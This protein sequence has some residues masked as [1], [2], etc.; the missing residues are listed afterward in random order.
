MQ[1]FIFLIYMLQIYAVTENNFSILFKTFLTTMKMIVSII[2]ILFWEILIVFSIKTNRRTD[3]IGKIE[4]QNLITRYDLYDAWRKLNPIKKRYS[5][6]RGNSKSRIDFILCSNGLCSKV[7]D[8]NIKHFPFSDYDLVSTK[9]KL[10]D[11]ERGPGIWAMNFNTITSELFTKAFNTW[12]GIWK[13]EIERF[14]NIQEWWD[15]TKTKIKY[16][17]MQISKQLKKVKIKKT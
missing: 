5:F 17:T 7:F 9:L 6:Q 16:L 3:D 14:R 2:T 8:T 12:W 11:I 10:D 13:N 4:L 15:V 1:C